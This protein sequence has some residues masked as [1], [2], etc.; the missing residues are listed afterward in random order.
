[1]GFICLD[2]KK[3]YN[4]NPGLQAGHYNG[5]F[6]ALKAA[7]QGGGLLARLPFGKQKFLGV[8]FKLGIPDSG[9][10]AC[11]LLAKGVK[12]LP[13]KVHMGVNRKARRMLFAHCADAER[14]AAGDRALL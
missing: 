1:M 2:L 11:I 10:S 4:F 14:S 9:K 3:A 5:L 7:K 6:A 12:G 13:E 8:P